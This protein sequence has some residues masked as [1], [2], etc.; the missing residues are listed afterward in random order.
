MYCPKHVG[1]E[2]KWN[3]YLFDCI[4]LVFS[5]KSRF[6]HLSISPHEVCTKDFQVLGCQK[7]CKELKWSKKRHNRGVEASILR[8][9]NTNIHIQ[10][11][12]SE[13]INK[14]NFI[15]VLGIYS[16]NE[17]EWW[18]NYYFCTII[19]SNSQIEILVSFSRSTNVNVN[20]S[21]LIVILK[22]TYVLSKLFWHYRDLKSECWKSRHIICKKIL[23][24]S[25]VWRLE[26]FVKEWNMYEVHIFPRPLQQTCSLETTP[27]CLNIRLRVNKKF[28]NSH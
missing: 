25:Y 5:F 1:T 27:L 13:Y 16:C 22:E 20:I 21:F 19:I 12:V 17:L 14:H 24:F 7:W 28:Q 3:I 10:N 15:S 26:F 18:Q 4:T 23:N 2:L 8:I 9:G 11:N 6:S